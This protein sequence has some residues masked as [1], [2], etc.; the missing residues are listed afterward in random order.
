MLDDQLI[1]AKFDQLNDHMASGFQSI[2]ERLAKIEEARTLHADI[3]E[4]VK[5]LELSVSWMRGAAKIGTIIWSGLSGLGFWLL[6]H[7]R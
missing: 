5:S 2:G 6:R 7:H 3:P 1:I 4:R